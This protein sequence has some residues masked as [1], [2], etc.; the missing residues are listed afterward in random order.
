MD[1]DGKHGVHYAVSTIAIPSVKGCNCG[2]DRKRCQH[3]A[4]IARSDMSV[5]HQTKTSGHCNT[6]YALDHQLHIHMFNRL[7]FLIDLQEIHPKLGFRAIRD[8]FRPRF[9]E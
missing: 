7:Y 6:I 9:V 5:F 4:P 2:G 1:G 8:P 3:P